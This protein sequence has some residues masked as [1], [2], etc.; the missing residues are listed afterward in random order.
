ME[1]EISQ[2]IQWQYIPQLQEC[3]EIFVVDDDEIFGKFMLKMF[4]NQGYEAKHFKTALEFLARLRYQVP[5]LIV[6]DVYMSWINGIDLAKAIRKNP[7]LKNVP[8]LMV[9]G[10][11]NSEIRTQGFKAGADAFLEKPFATG[12]LMEMVGTLL[13]TN[14]GRSSFS[15]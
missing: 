13:K 11:P 4:R 2:E 7:R 14:G 1:G 12:D 8:I 10:Y 9:T 6:L 3:G 5:K 15:D